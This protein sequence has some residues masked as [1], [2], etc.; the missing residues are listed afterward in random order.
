LVFTGSHAYPHEEHRNARTYMIDWLKQRYGG[1]RFRVYTGGIRNRDHADLCASATIII[2]DSCLAGKLDRYWSERI[3]E[4]LGRA[5]FL[6]HPYCPG[7][8]NSYRDGAHLR[9]YDAG[10]MLQL[11]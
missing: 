10:D 8:E 9:W 11:T 3:P 5:G 7:L 4:T 6:I 1:R 2:G